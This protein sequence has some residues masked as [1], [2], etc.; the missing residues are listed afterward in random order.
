[1]TFQIGSLLIRLPAALGIGPLGIVSRWK[2]GLQK[3]SL[4]LKSERLASKSNVP[5]NHEGEILGP[6]AHLLSAPAPKAPPFCQDSGKLQKFRILN[7][8]RSTCEMLIQSLLPVSV[9]T[10]LSFTS[11]HEN[12]YL[13]ERK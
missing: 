1:M 6:F 13:Q 11:E 3:N 8:R 10:E 4:M 2:D 12:H 5:I 7:F 9:S